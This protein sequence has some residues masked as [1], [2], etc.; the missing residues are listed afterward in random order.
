MLVI[1]HTVPYRLVIYFSYYVYCVLRKGTMGERTLKVKCKN[2]IFR[3][4]TLAANEGTGP[5]ST[6]SKR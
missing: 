4:Q 5:G 3:E 2:I 6:F 1:M